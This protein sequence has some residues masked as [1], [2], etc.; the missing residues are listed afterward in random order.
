MEEQVNLGA[1]I[2]I[3]AINNNREQVTNLLLKN[4]V[5]APDNL[6]DY[7]LAQVVTELLKV[8]KNFKKEFLSFVSHPSNIETMVSMSGYSNA[9]G[10]FSDMFSVSPSPFS[11]NIFSTNSTTATTPT[12]ASTVSTAP[13][14]G[15][16]LDKALNIFGQSLNA[17]LQLD[18]NATNRALANASVVNAQSGGVIPEE[19][20]ADVSKKSN[21][22]LYVVLAILGV[23]V[24]GGGIWYAVKSKKD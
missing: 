9:S 5:Q 22:T 13:K 16:T 23:V 18:T 7:Q 1:S 20:I 14:T 17:L 3:S 2:I 12:T 21:T 4:G 24:I 11:T 10:T 6:S 15:F 8:S 19:Q